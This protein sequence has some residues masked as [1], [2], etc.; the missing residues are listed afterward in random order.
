MP[1]SAISPSLPITIFVGYS[2]GSITSINLGGVNIDNWL[3][4]IKGL[5]QEP[6]RSKRCGVCFYH[7]FCKTA[8]YAYENN[9]LLYTSSLAISRMKDIKQVIDSGIKA[10][11]NFDGVNYWDYNWRKE[12][13]VELA[14]KISKTENFYRQKYCGCIFSIINKK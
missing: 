2:L 8:K 6:E 13:R 11:S 1:F 14:S 3:E 5:E 12:G 9:Y 7:R 4:K 10:A